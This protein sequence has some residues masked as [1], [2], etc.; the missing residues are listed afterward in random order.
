MAMGMSYGEMDGLYISR[1][2]KTSR[3]DSD[4]V[5]PMPMPMLCDVA[6]MYGCGLVRCTCD[7][8]HPPIL[9][10]FFLV[11]QS[12]HLYQ[13]VAFGYYRARLIHTSLFGAMT[14]DMSD[15]GDGHMLLHAAF[16][17]IHPG[18]I[19][20]NTALQVELSDFVSQRLS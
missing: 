17:V 20:K 6:Y 10:F 3:P 9:T 12:L 19:Q 8:Y 2:A 18:A 4:S 11:G 15:T 14:R 16:H 13:L 5:M 1:W 7:G